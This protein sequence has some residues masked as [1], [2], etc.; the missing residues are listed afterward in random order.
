MT[1]KKKIFLSILFAFM[2]IISF[3]QPLKSCKDGDNLFKSENVSYN[4]DGYVKIFDCDKF[5]KIKTKDCE[6]EIYIKI[7]PGNIDFLV[8]SDA[9]GY[10][11]FLYDMFGRKL[12]D[13]EIKYQAEFKKEGLTNG[14]YLIKITDGVNV[15][16]KRINI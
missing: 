13:K 1:M 2:M 12:V 6:V 7:N 5:T 15:Y 14:L 9:T 16:T 10:E 4:S 8:K 11:I 3:S